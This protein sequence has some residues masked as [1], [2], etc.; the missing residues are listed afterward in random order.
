MFIDI[1]S[2]MSGVEYSARNLIDDIDRNAEIN[3]NSVLARLVGG[4]RTN[5]FSR[6][7]R[8]TRCYGAIVSFNNTA[9]YRTHVHQA[10]FCQNPRMYT[11]VYKKG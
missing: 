4:K 3:F 1:F 7:S 11:K 10:V 6:Q 2:G 9:D 5:Y 8:E